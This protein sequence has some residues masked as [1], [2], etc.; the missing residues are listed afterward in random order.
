MSS[1]ISVRGW[2]SKSTPEVKRTI[3]SIISAD[4][5]E[6]RYIVVGEYRVIPKNFSKVYVIK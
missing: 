2:E 6:G 4:M 5:D 3:V 1:H